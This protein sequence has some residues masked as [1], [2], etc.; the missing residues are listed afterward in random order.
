MNRVFADDFMSIFSVKRLSDENVYSVVG[1]HNVRNG[2][3]LSVVVPIRFAEAGAISID[4]V[5]I[6]LRESC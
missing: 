1:L 6:C 5:A 4:N 3:R 2:A